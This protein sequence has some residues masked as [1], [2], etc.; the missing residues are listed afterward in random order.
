MP[1]WLIAGLWALPCSAMGQV[2]WDSSEDPVAQVRAQ[3]SLR[4]AD[5]TPGRRPEAGRLE[6]VFM[7]L[8]SLRAQSSNNCW[9]YAVTNMLE[10]RALF[11]DSIKLKIDVDADLAYWVTFERLMDAHRFHAPVTAVFP[12]GGDMTEYLRAFLMHGSAIASVEKS[13]GA[14]ELRCP[15]TLFVDGRW[16]PASPE[17][18]PLFEDLFGRGLDSVDELSTRLLWLENSEAAGESVREHLA[19]HFPR[20]PLSKTTWF[21]R[22]VPIASVP[23]LVF[24][25][26]YRKDMIE[27]FVL[28]PHGGYF[29]DEF[30]LHRRSVR[31]LEPGPQGGWDVGRLLRASLEQHWPVV[32]EDKYH[33]YTVIGFQELKDESPSRTMYAVANPM[34]TIEWYGDSFFGIGLFL[35]YEPAIRAPLER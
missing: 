15:K 7:P 19:R 1:Y 22:E 27:D 32:F 8:P 4:K 25:K 13:A 30:G 31:T 14:A 24:G 16:Q 2:H 21:G 28:M 20:P 10:A 9:A 34:G 23:E 35:F 6:Y 12:V 29:N 33:V 17:D 18:H 26:D 11:R 3:S 5:S